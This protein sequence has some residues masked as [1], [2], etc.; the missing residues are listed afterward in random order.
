MVRRA[1]RPLALAACLAMS[2]AQVS[3]GR[4]QE[5]PRPGITSRQAVE[6]TRVMRN[7]E[8]VAP[9]NP[10]G[11]ISISPDGRR[12]VLRLVRGDAGSNRAIL[13]LFA[14]ELSSLDA[15]TPVRIATLASTGFGIGGAVFGPVH[16]V[17]EY[18]SPVRWLD[19]THLAF[20]MSD[21]N[22]VRQVVRVDLTTRRLDYL[23]AHPTNVVA[24]DISPQGDV[25][26]NAQ[27]A[28]PESDS[29]ARIRAGF[30]VSAGMDA[31]SL[32]RRDL[33]GRDLF[34]NAWST[35]WFVRR[36]RAA[37]RTYRLPGRDSELHYAHR[38]NW[39]PDG[40]IVLLNATADV[41]PENWNRYAEREMAARIA[42]F[43]RDPR[44]T[45]ARSV[46][47]LF[48]I[49]MATGQA[50]PLWSAVSLLYLPVAAWS[51]DSRSVLLAP[52]F[53][54]PEADDSTTLGGSAAAI[55]DVAT[56]S[57]ARLPITIGGP[58]RVAGVRWT[59]RDRVEIDIREGPAV[60][61]HR[62]A[63]EG[64]RWVSAGEPETLSGGAGVRMELRQ[65]LDTP[66]RLF[67]VHG[68]TGQERMVLDLNPGLA[69]RVSLGRA[70]RV[71]GTLEG[72]V[73]WAGLLFY[74][75]D[76]TPGR[77]YPLVIQSVYG[78]R[79]DD[80]FSLYGLQGG[81]GLGPTPIAPY[82]G[83]ALAA[84]GLFVLHLDVMMSREF[85]TPAE[86]ELRWRAFEAAIAELDRR[87]LI[88]PARVGLVGFS[89]NGFYVEY[90]LTHSEHP[91]AAAIS[92]DN[93]DPSY[94]QQTL[95]MANVAAASAT[96]GA[97]PFGEGLA[98][99][100]ERA[101]GFSADRITSPLLMIE[102]SSGL[103]GVFTRWETYSRLRHLRRPVE[104]YV[105]P[106]AD[107]HGAHN[108]QNPGQILAVMER[109]TDWFDFW[110]N[111]RED[112]DP[113]RS[114]QYEGWRRLRALQAEAARQP[115]R[116]ALRWTAAPVE[117]RSE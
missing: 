9:G 28:P 72:G 14:G 101:P 105:M 61:R 63:R 7:P 102:Q 115:R 94:F 4:A 38:I 82:P 29:Q 83:R 22:G 53:L 91:F 12:Y 3:E 44:G 54:P 35:Q 93:W 99:W 21:S 88:D 27:A 34:D 32:F 11:L 23:T 114:E 17:D 16:D 59:S 48:V 37:A 73:G 41:A 96:H 85:G 40:R 55:V 74:P 75:P 98:A 69:E 109:A 68:A 36:G 51:P 25:F 87:Q 19:D 24:F 84:R 30:V 106:D 58:L 42:D 1:A 5:T 89:R 50:R 92:A 67:A 10:D 8:A 46:H 43:R 66:P 64:E 71:Q 100:L 117:G 56:G 77:R 81:S 49:D 15:A 33:S 86:P 47:R 65:G 108:T 111:G 20:L 45:N 97:E 110:L 90:T 57:H 6:T 103:F 62:F 26:Y 60:I 13:D 79:I 104:F 18:G 78:T 95:V 52:T 116:P 107:R 112:P 31:S 80:N 113:A 76:H 70:E 2:L 39:S